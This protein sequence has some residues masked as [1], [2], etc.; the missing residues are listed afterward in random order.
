VPRDLP[1][2]PLATTRLDPELLHRGLVAA[3]LLQP[4]DDNDEE[5]SPWEEAEYPPTL[6]D[7]LCLLFDALYPHVTDVHTQS[8]WCA[9]ELLVF[10][11]NF[12]KYAQSGD[13][14]K[15]EGIVFR[16]LLRL[17]L[18]SGEFA[19][20]CPP[21]IAM[22]EW[23]AELRALAERLRASCRAIDPASTDET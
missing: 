11:E 9:G 16:H 22:E 21:G 5:L 23:Q 12:T 7:K 19:Q 18:L 15:Q 6:S 20:F 8:V 10:S 4:A 3:H 17:I 14:G 2:G 13:L 1:S